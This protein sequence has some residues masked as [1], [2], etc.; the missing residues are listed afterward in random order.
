MFDDLDKS[1]VMENSITHEIP[2][3]PFLS[4][5]KFEQL[6]IAKHVQ[7]FSNLVNML[8]WS[9]NSYIPNSTS[10][11]KRYIDQSAPKPSLS[12]TKFEQLYIG[13]F[14]LLISNFVDMFRTSN[15]DT[16]PSGASRRIVL[17]V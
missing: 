1:H 16:T 4:I 9:D 8:K 14:L 2:S 17:H 13:N 3:K 10:C 5:L 7:M 15:D 12:K 11:R 6:Y